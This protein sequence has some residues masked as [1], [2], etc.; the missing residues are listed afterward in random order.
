MARTDAAHGVWK[1]PAGMEADLK[2]IY[3]MT[4]NSNS[5]LDK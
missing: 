4:P 3:L 5:S 2:N 1:T